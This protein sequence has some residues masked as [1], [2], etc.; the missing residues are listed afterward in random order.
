MGSTP[1][2]LP[3]IFAP[4][5][6]RVISQGFQPIIANMAA[7]YV[8][9]PVSPRWSHGNCD[10]HGCLASQEILLYYITVKTEW[11]HLYS[12][13]LSW[14]SKL[15]SVFGLGRLY[16]VLVQSMSPKW[17]T[18]VWMISVSVNMQ[19]LPSYA[20]HKRMNSEK[21]ISAIQSLAFCQFRSP[22]STP[23]TIRGWP[24]SQMC[25]KLLP[26]DHM[27]LGSCRRLERCLWTVQIFS[28]FIW[29]PSI[30]VTTS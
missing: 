21:S 15:D 28:K 7:M 13:L 9:L 19:A 24:L 30:H 27:L 10:N 20:M 14:Q 5:D 29:H 2:P 12:G 23:L 4:G 25:W 6:L 17:I 18:S 8:P 3:C 16:V 22:W 11:V 26:T 1:I